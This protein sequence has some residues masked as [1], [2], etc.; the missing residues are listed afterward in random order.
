VDRPTPHRAAHTPLDREDS[1]ASR[2]ER[3]VAG[4]LEGDEEIRLAFSAYTGSGLGRR[5]VGVTN[6]RFLLI[7]SRYW[8]VSDRGLLWTD[9]VDGIALG[10]RG[11]RPHTTEVGVGNA[12]VVVRRP[13]GLGVPLNPRSGF[14]GGWTSA[15]ATIAALYE[16]VPGRSAA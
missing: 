7:R 9:P 5:V 16:A 14:L 10:E 12:Y 4:Y 1:L 13:N 2:E 3:I 11:G 8:A 15:R 6:R